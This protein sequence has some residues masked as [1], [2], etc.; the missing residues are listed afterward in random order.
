MLTAPFS[1]AATI[2]FINMTEASAV[3]GGYGESAWNPMALSFSDFN[4]SITGHATNDDANADGSADTAQYAY[5]DWGNAGLGVCKDLIN[6]STVN[7]KF[8]KSGT[9]LCAPGSDDNVTAGEYLTFI[10]DRD[11]TINNIW[12][13]N[14]HDPDWLLANGDKITIDG[15]NTLVNTGYAGGANGIGSFNVAANTAFNVGYF[16]EQFYVSGME[17]TARVPTP[18]SLAV[19]GLGLLGLRICARRR[20]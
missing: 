3:D 14:N 6:S 11:V 7:T 2:D 9:N 8:P 19:L 18:T 5:L 1:S 4:M 15:A 17:I 16:N 10:F 12:F 13:N 20:S